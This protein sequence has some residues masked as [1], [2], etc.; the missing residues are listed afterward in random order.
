MKY[1]IIS[2]IFTLS[3]TL[4]GHPGGLDAKGGHLD[5]KNG[6]Y[7]IHK[8][9]TDKTEDAGKEKNAPVEEK[10]SVEKTE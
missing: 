2:L 7:H 10:A 9:A 5:K 1:S 4:N 3:F 8:P 6:N